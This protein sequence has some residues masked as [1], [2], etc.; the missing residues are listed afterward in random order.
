MAR[1]KQKNPQRNY[2]PPA[3]RGHYKLQKY[4]LTRILHNL[5]LLYRIR[6]LRKQIDSQKNGQAYSSNSKLL[7]DLPETT[8]PPPTMSV[9]EESP[10]TPPIIIID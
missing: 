1:T 4:M 2:V 3:V 8:L 5:D 9:E 6:A 7:F 10:T